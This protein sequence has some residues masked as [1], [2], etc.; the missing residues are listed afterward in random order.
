MILASWTTIVDVS[1]ATQR[2]IT[3]EVVSILKTFIACTI[4]E[5]K[6]T[7]KIASER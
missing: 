1:F 6:N 7:N 4:G 3:T 2:T 5:K